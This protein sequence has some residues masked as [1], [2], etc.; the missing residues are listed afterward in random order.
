M[1]EVGRPTKYNPEYIE[2]V[3]SYVGEQGKSVTQFAF[4]LRVSKSTVYLW[5]QEYPEFSDALTLAQEWSQA[6]WETKLKDMMMSREVNAPLVKLYFANRFKWTDKAP[7]DEDEETKAQPLAITFEVRHA[8]DSIEIT[9][10][11][12]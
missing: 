5:A 2:Q 6:A 12:P 3:L 8:A 11:K 1:S 9:N 7:A 10:A 4:H